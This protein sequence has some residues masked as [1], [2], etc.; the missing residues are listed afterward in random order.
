MTAVEVARP[1]RATQEGFTPDDLG[2]EQ[3]QRSYAAMPGES[4]L[5]GAMRVARH[6]AAAEDA[7]KRDKW[8]RRFYGEIAA[9]RFMPGGRIMY[10]AGRPKAQLLN[11]YVTSVGDSRESWGNLI[12]ETLVISGSGGGIGT[13]F[14]AVRPRGSE[15]K[16]TGGYATGPVSIM[17][18]DNSIGEE[19]VAGGGRRMARMY[20]LDILHPDVKEFLDCKLEDGKLNNANI[21]IVLNMPTEDFQRYVRDDGYLALEWNGRKTGE[22]VSAREVWSRIVENAWNNGEPG[23]L[24]GHLANQL[25]NIY[26]HSPLV[27]TNPCGEIWLEPYGCCCLGAL[28]LPRFVEDGDVNWE[29]LE[30]TVRSSVRFLDDVLTVNQYPLDRIKQNCEDVR[31]IGLGVMGLHTMLLELGLRYSSKQAL[32]FVD[33]LFSFLKHSAYD[34]S[35]ALAIEKGPFP[36]FKEE[37]CDSGFM[38]S[39]K[40]AIRR[41]VREYGIRNCALMTIAPTG[42]TGMVQGVSTGIEPYMAPVYWRK[43]RTGSGQ[44]ESYDD[45]LVI[46]PAYEKYGD[47]CEGAADITPAQHFAMQCAVQ[48]HIDNAVSKTI[49]LPEDYP[50]GDLGEL[51]LEHLPELKGT[52]FYRWGS[53]ENEPFRPVKLADIPRTLAETPE[54]QVRR[55]HVAAD[56]N[57]MDCVNGSCDVPP[58]QAT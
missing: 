43:R 18:M 11:C 7:E 21:S 5:A 17:R 10:G 57:A 2:M 46:E 29:M 24:N 42:T 16:G 34:T 9:G 37:F 44:D 4:W 25:N 15:V 19:L 3:F 40:P 58:S 47:L 23:V 38:K 27:C 55:K 30:D 52:T 1:E 33:R 31:R 22:K 54:E 14:S 35:I 56:Q 32:G 36:A 45:V 50:L 48:P 51:W 12:N 20:S 26:Y 6:V 39:M 49:N 41:K 13:D 53:R 28:V 8:E